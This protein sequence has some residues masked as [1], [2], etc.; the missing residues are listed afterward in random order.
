[1]AHVSQQS[2]KVVRENRHSFNY[3]NCGHALNV[4]TMLVR[5]QRKTTFALTNEAVK[6]RSL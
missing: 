4:Q 5:S 3:Q 1:M 2:C 6:A